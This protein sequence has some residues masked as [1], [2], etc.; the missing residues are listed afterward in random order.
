MKNNFRYLFYRRLVTNFFIFSLFILFTF[1]IATNYK[2]SLDKNM[3]FVISLSIT[4]I[5][6]YIIQPFLY[7][8]EII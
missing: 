8:K 7:R 3:Y 4:I 5:Y 2:E 6:Y 1:Y